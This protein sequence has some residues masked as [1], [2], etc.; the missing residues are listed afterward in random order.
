[1]S[2]ASDPFR[3]LVAA[4]RRERGRLFGVGGAPSLEAIVNQEYGGFNTGWVPT[5]FHVRKFLKAFFTEHGA[6]YGCNTPVRQNGLQ[7][8]WIEKPSRQ[9]P[10]RFGFY[11]VSP[12]T[13]HDRSPALGAL[14]LDYSRGGNSRLDPARLLRDYLV[15]VHPGSDELLLGKAYAKLGRV[16]IPVSYFVLQRI[17]PVVSEIRLPGG[18]TVNSSGS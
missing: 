11:S 17:R 6:T 9:N 13:W 18:T 3:Q 5:L 16:R 8:E 4:S 15:R 7:G 14:L 12:A 2:P 10:K 1:M